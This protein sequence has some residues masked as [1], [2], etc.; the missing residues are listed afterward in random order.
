MAPPLAQLVYPGGEREQV[1]T[2]YGRDMVVLA[3][4]K[5]FVRLALHNGLP[6]VPMYAFGEDRLYRTLGLGRGLRLWMVRRLK[7]A[8]VLA[9]GRWGTPWPRRSP[10]VGVVGRPLDLGHHPSPTREQVDEAHAKYVRAL[11]D[12]FDRHKAA[13]A[14][15]GAAARLEIR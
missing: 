13:C 4:K 5:G 3:D 2:E 1:Q 7:V 15:N 6:V 8:L 14:P 12:L 10:L 11:M 9:L